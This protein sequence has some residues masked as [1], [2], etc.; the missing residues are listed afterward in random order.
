MDVGVNVNVGVNVDVDIAVDVGVDVGLNVDIAVDVGV[1]IG[2]GN[3]TWE[4]DV[5]IGRG[6]WT[7]KLAWELEVGTGVDVWAWK[8]AWTWASLYVRSVSNK[9]TK[10]IEL[11]VRT[12]VPDRAREGLQC[13]FESTFGPRGCV[14]STRIRTIHPQSTRNKGKQPE[15]PRRTYQ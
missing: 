7:W 12:W 6:N 3:W 1:G 9:W 13:L 14:A 8:L 11:P 2:R 5:E 4:L 10:A 15:F